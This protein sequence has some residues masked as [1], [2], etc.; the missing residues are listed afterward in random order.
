MTVC[1]IL[2]WFATNG[3]AGDTIRAEIPLLS[4]WKFHL[5]SIA[6]ASAVK[7]DDAAWAV[8]SLPHGWR[9][10][11]QKTG[12]DHYFHG[13]GWYRRRFKIDDAWRGRRLF[14][15]FDGA[16]RSAEVFLNGQRL[17]VHR[18]GFARFRFEIT[19]AVKLSED[20]VLA[21]RVNNDRD[22]N[23]IP[24]SADYTFFGGLYRGVSL[25]AT[26]PVHIDLLDY[27]SPGVYVT[28]REV[29]RKSAQLEVVAKLVNDQTNGV[30]TVV[31][32][33]VF[34]ADG[35]PVAVEKKTVM[36]AAQARLATTLTLSVA[37]PHL[38]DGLADPYLYSVRTEIVAGDTI[39]DEVTLP[40]GLR[41]FA[42]DPERG[43]S[44]N[45]HYL[46]L[47]GV[48]RHQD[49][50]DK[51]WATTEAE[52]REDFALIREMG[53]TAVRQSHYQQSQSWNDL[54][55]QRGM[56]MWAELAYV[57]E[58]RDNREFF[59][60]AKEQLRELIRQNYHHASILFWSIGNET[61]VRDR[62][63]TAADANDRLLE[64][65]AAVARAE[66]GT[67][68]STYASNGDG[69]EPR[70]TFTDVVG[71]NHY[72]GWY[73]GT[74]DDFAVW[75]DAQHAAHPQLCL[76][77]SE[78]GA[79]ANIAHHEDPAKKPEARGQWHPEEWQAAYH[80]A[81]WQT[82][83]A[84]SWVWGKFIWCMFDFSSEGRNEGGISGVNDKGLVTSDRKT[85]KDAFYWYKA[86]WSEEP[87]LYIT[88]R[89]F[90]KRT[91]AA[92]QVKIYSNAGTV[93]LKVNGVSLGRKSSSNHIFLWSN[94][95]LTKGENRIEA[96]A[97]RESQVLTDSCMWT[98]N[99]P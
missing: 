58:V 24:V 15:Q 72:F 1:L 19:D 20:N 83:A 88:S 47:R 44:L 13:D 64:E 32:V 98:Y 29:T 14:L 17:G 33:T 51:G 23:M 43:F 79:G 85:R 96:S 37:Q 97:T 10:S 75:L 46:D 54:G 40:L 6:E 74:L 52:E 81:Y 7:F 28:S 3:T 56:I 76:G 48:N 9:L 34:D 27:A 70:A 49:W 25:V 18:G 71:F 30:E 61:F 78:Y 91:Q 31:R 11:D 38:W 26:D 90:V 66:D 55:D 12:S 62:K 5:G 89:R 87:V 2:L 41:F 16:N 21:V 86:N 50:S 95:S 93:E 42:V 39:R 99:A 92:T 68:L 67:R 82:L 65:L 69:S 57:N 73:R 77:M 80:E 22:D 59:D 53:A 36:L 94:V 60:N 8:I 4:D 35:H 63:V 84:R 45:G